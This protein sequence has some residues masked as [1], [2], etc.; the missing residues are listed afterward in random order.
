MKAFRKANGI[1][2]SGLE[3]SVIE[4]A[5]RVVKLVDKCEHSFNLVN[6][7]L[8][9]LSDQKDELLDRIIKLEK[10]NED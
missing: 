6:A 4:I 10:V 8:L 7:H 1:R 3:Q 5:E 9:I 2:I